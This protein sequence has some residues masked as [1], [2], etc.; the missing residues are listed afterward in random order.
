LSG[1]K[2]SSDSVCLKLK[3]NP[4]LP[5]EAEVLS[6][7]IIRG[8]S[9]DEIRKL[10]VFLGNRQYLLSDF[11]D[12]EG[13]KSNR[14]ELHGN[15]AQV[16]WI[17]RGM[18][19]GTVLVHGNA[20]MHLG[21]EMKGGSI[22]VNGNAGDWVGA[23][24]TGGFISIR[25]NAGG[26]IG[27]AYRGSLKGMRGGMILIEGTAGMEI[28]MRMRRGLICIGDRAG[29]FTGLQMLGGTIIL[30]GRPGLR[31]GAWM[32]R[33]T[34]VALEPPKLL[35]TFQ[36]ACTYEPG[37]LLLLLKQLRDLGVPLPEQEWNVPVLRYTG[38]TSGLGKGEIL[39]RR[40][41]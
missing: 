20:G 29:D 10:P 13:E 27:A 5:L 34:I 25:G 23:E 41:N 32:S 12:V 7:D 6:P 28:G 36:Y 16:K 33:G 22:T 2:M 19:G 30:C 26:Q 4:K 24:M 3:E 9:R 11:F 40:K 14:L 35:P 21:G 8:L 18:S 1:E 37:F 15:L 31:T 38:D 17:G 39:F